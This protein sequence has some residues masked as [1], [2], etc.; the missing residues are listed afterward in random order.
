MSLL[1]LGYS[2]HFRGPHDKELKAP[3]NSHVSE[4]GSE[5]LNPSQVFRGYSPC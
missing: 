1:R 5:S 4:R 2:R 3:A